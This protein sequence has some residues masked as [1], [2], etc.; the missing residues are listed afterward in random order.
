MKKASGGKKAPQ[1]YV[2][3]LDKKK[4]LDGRTTWK[5]VLHKT[6]KACIY[7]YIEPHK[8]QVLTQRIDHNGVLSQCI[9]EKSFLD[10]HGHQQMELLVK[11]YMCE[12]SAALPKYQARGLFD[13]GPDVE[14][15]MYSEERYRIH[16]DPEA[17][18]LKKKSL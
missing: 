6:D 9:V 1:F 13:F 14:Q 10:H 18:A 4:S 11:V 8:K 16:F 3:K 12:D 7:P 5:F 15:S 2:F 17:L